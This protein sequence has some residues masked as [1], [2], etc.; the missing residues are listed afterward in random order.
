MAR[1]RTAARSG[2]GV[3]THVPGPVPAEG[4]QATRGAP[5]WP[6]RPTGLAIPHPSRDT[7]RDEAE[8]SPT[9]LIYIF[10]AVSI[11]TKTSTA[12]S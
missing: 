5:A 3:D 4:L 6:L 2:A 8:N 12:F 7:G 10:K 11:K 1:Q 9:K